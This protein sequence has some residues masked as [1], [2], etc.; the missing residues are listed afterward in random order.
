MGENRRKSVLMVVVLFFGMCIS[1][2]IIGIEETVPIF[3]DDITVVSIQP[4]AQCVEKSE[5]FDIGIYVEPSE[6]IKG[7][8]VDIYFDPTLIQA[9][10][11]VAV[12]DLFKWLPVWPP[13]GFDP[14]TI[15][16]INGSITGIMG[17]EDA[18]SDPGYFCN[19]TFI[20]QQKPGTS[21]LDLQKVR[22][23]D[24]NSELLPSTVIDGEVTV[25]KEPPQITNVMLTT[26]DPLDTEPGFGWENISCTV[27]DDNEI[28]EVK[29][30]IVWP[31][32]TM[33]TMINIPG[34]DTYYIN[35]TFAGANR[36]YNYYISANDTYGN[37]NESSMMQFWLPH[38]A[39]VNMDGRIGLIDLIQITLRCRNTGPPGWIREDVNNDG[40]VDF[41]DFITVLFSYFSFILSDNSLQQ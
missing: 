38:N 23:L 19:I 36:Y 22:I 11:V 3:D 14:G 34:T 40:R 28:D 4:P 30:A 27:I 18:V 10:E 31:D 12:W 41:I 37:R 33:A 29:F 39:D 2:S 8:A 24:T 32:C 26:S 9:D 16:N 5:W 13:P 25:G 1:P 7:V 17:V 15:D 6:P 35:T 21:P 20:A